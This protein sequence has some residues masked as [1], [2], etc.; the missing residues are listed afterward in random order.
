MLSSRQKQRTLASLLFLVPIVVAC[1]GGLTNAPPQSPQAGAQRD[2]AFAPDRLT[3]S[4]VIKSGPLASGYEVRGLRKG[5]FFP[6]SAIITTVSN[7]LL[8]RAYGKIWAY[9]L[10]GVR[11]RRMSSGAWV[12]AKHLSAER[13]R[14]LIRVYRES[15]R[16]RIPAAPMACP[17]C[18]AVFSDIVPSDSP[19]SQPFA[20]PPPMPSPSPDP[21]CTGIGPGCGVAPGNTPEPLA[22]LNPDNVGGYAYR[23][24]WYYYFDTTYLFSKNWPH[25][26]VYLWT[27]EYLDVYGDF[28]TGQGIAY[29]QSGR[30]SWF[31]INSYTPSSA[32]QA[33]Q[34][35]LVPGAGCGSIFHYDGTAWGNGADI[36]Y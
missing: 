7:E 34:W 5:Y 1:S 15:V 2:G 16:T 13:S 10:S 14:A 22:T 17:D 8:V 3:D 29:D 26:C 20:T 31:V 9:R 33:W 23:Y 12:D 11:V 35:T 6:Q 18:D 21:N 25:P 36:V 24:A 28:S 30:A 32:L 4:T 27:A 19:T